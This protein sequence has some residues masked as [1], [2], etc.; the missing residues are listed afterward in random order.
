MYIEYSD[1]K[2]EKRCKDLCEAKKHY[3]EKVAKKLLKAIN[4]IEN[5]ESLLDVINYRSF[6]FH[7]LKGNRNGQY[8]IDVDGR[9]SSYRIIL[10]LKDNEV[11]DVYAIAKTIKIIKIMGVSKHY[12]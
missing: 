6:A 7:K 12:E 10:E 1:K 8:A 3:P 9:R 5:A 4:Y 11:A 2:T